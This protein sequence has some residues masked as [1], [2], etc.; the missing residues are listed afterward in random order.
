M[1]P[2]SVPMSEQATKD[3][4]H[5]DHPMGDPAAAARVLAGLRDFDPVTALDDLG[6]YVDAVKK[7]IP[8]GDE[9]VRGE[10][11]SLIQEAGEAHVSAVLAR[12][13][14]HPR[15][16]AARE[17]D[18]STLNDYVRELA[19][20]LC[21]SARI[22]LSKAASTPSLQHAG[23]AGAARG[24]HTART[25]AKVYLLRYLTVPP[26]LWQVAYAVHGDAEKAGCAT[27]A[28]R[29]HAAQKTT[30]TVTQELLRMLMLQTSSPEM[31]TPEQIDA[32]DRLIEHLGGDFTLRPPGVSDN[33]FC[34]DPASDHP[35]HRAP[36]Q[37]P[38]PDSAIRYF[39]P[40][41]GYDALDRLQH[42]L[43]TASAADMKVLARDV[44]PNVQIAAVRHLHESWGRESP[45]A[46][47]VH[48]PATGTLQV[49]H[50]YGQIW[51]HISQ[52]RSSGA[53]ELALVEEG[54]RA[55]APAAPET[56]ALRDAGG[57]ELGVEVAQ[58]LSGRA[59]C[60]DLLGVTL[61]GKNECWVGMIRSLHAEPG[62]GLHVNIS[63]MSQQP[64]AVQLR[65]V[66]KKGEANVVSEAA[67]RQ[68]D[69]KS[70]KAIIVSDGAG[71]Q[72]ASYLLS[73]ASW[74]EGRVYEVTIG[75]ATRFLRSLHVVRRGDD[76]VR[77]AFEWV[78]QP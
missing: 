52:V 67:A 37:P 25:L 69:F 56:W 16:R 53:T 31:M 17:S 77:A 76:F 10:I 12:F 72:K 43:A 45:H 70:V 6:T 49:I 26:K 51:Q 33:P 14:A 5:P 36:G 48:K 20:T 58:S 34:F 55:A 7:G 57:N 75:G 1:Q 8:G 54:D 68:F 22:L 46:P 50:G 35:P 60:G 13:V 11:L 71:T 30:T 44:P 27:T 29:M 61:Q 73:L 42:Q 78:Q 32:A 59:R 74:E 63:V 41:A 2:G 4:G 40:G 9:Q 62:R 18:W 65:P 38:G 47:P 19:G 66:I 23:A 21:A 15:D 24:L 3:H 39:G 28:V 64:Q